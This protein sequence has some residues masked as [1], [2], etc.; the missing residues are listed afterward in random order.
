MQYANTK[1]NVVTHKL[2]IN[3]NMQHNMLTYIFSAISEE[4]EELLL[5]NTV[6]AQWGSV[7][8][9]NVIYH[10]GERLRI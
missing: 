5:E 3:A 2:S 1:K 7:L 8:M 4:K 9:E 6:V 10:Q